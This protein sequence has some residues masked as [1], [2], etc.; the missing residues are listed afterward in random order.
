MKTINS[1]RSILVKYT[2]ITSTNVFLVGLWLRVG[3][4]RRFQHLNH[5]ISRLLSLP[6]FAECPSI[7]RPLCSDGRVRLGLIGSVSGRHSVPPTVIPGISSQRLLRSSA[8]SN[9]SFFSPGGL[10][11]HALCLSYKTS[12]EERGW[13]LMLV[14]QY[15]SLA[16]NNRKHFRSS[17]SNEAAI[18]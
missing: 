16:F 13:A 5:Q 8:S 7:S 4:E 15:R 6:L 3:G 2:C 17:E 9:S 14:S 10:H 1:H 18:N 12:L 11:L